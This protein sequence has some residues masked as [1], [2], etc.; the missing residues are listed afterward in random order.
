[1]SG[2]VQAG[3]ASSPTVEDEVV[4]TEMSAASRRIKRITTAAVLA[5]LSVAMAPTAAFLPRLPWGIAL[6]DPSSLF[7]LVAFLVGG[8]EVGLLCM[9][10]GS[11]GLM[12][13][14]PT[15]VGVFFKV[16]A[17]M[18]MI[19]VPWLG[20]R[21]SAKGTSGDALG[22]PRTYV[23][24][25]AAAYLVRVTVMVF[26]NVVIGPVLVPFLLQVPVTE[27]IWVTVF[28]NTVQSVFDSLIPFII[29]HPTTVFR[30][31]R[32]W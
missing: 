1:M 29:V 19:L 6:F 31:F 32:M 27:I 26:V 20:L 12:Y 9:A 24:L 10:A 23:V 28:V 17:T 22:R 2:Q 18:P 8:P 30:H 21:L 3:T 7:W 25:M 16:A 15:G 11:I 5:S 13:F 4:L 14:D